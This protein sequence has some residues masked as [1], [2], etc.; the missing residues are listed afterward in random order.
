MVDRENN[1]LLKLKRHLAYQAAVANVGDR[2]FNK[3]ADFTHAHVG[4]VTHMNGNYI[5]TVEGNVGSGGAT[6][7]RCS[8]YF[9]YKEWNADRNN[10]VLIFAT[11]NWNA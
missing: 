2:V 4:F 9:I 8:E 5:K 11:P 1:Y 10:Q 6:I 3:N 7:L